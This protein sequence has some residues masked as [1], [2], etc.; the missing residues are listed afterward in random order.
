[1]QLFVI[2]DTAMSGKSVVRIFLK[3][4]RAEFFLKDKSPHLY[5]LEEHAA[6]MGYAFPSKLFAAHYLVEGCDIHRFIGFHTTYDN[7]KR[8]VG[9][10]GLVMSFVPE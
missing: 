4:N 5:E 10:T 6:P 8:L 3:L 7:A 9:E 2:F 1:V